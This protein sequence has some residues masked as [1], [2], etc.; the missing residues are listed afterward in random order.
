MDVPVLDW[1]VRENSNVTSAFD[2]VMSSAKH[3]GK[4]IIG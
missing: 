3:I 4:V 1:K 2:N